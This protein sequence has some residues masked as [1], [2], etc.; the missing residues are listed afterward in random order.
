MTP[1]GDG[2]EQPSSREG[3]FRLRVCSSSRVSASSLSFHAWHGQHGDIRRRR[4]RV[5]LVALELAITA[6]RCA[7]IGRKH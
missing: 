4:T 6:T 2:E 7:T 1:A 3:P 5:N